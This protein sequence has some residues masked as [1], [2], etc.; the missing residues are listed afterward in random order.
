MRDKDHEWYC[1]DEG[2][3]SDDDDPDVRNEPNKKKAKGN[4][5]GSRIS[6]TLESE[7]SAT[8]CATPT[9]ETSRINSVKP[10]ATPLL[11]RWPVCP[12][13]QGQV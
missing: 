2:E 11:N 1:C 3:D 13:S 12:V 10:R 8:P 5:L 7:L 9:M 4:Q 6:S